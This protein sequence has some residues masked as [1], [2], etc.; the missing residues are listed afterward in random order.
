MIF[1]FMR[2]KK[3]YAAYHFTMLYLSSNLLWSTHL[4]S[5]HFLFC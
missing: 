2:E 1:K 3:K 5:K 4:A